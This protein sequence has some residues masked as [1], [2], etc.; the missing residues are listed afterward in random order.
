M[1]ITP[2]DTRSSEHPGDLLAWLRENAE[3]NDESL[4]RLRK[5]LSAAIQT[6]LTPRQQQILQLYLSSGLRGREIAAQ[7]GVA[8]STVSRTLSR[9]LGKLYK[10]LQWSF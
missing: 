8:P 7:L 4:L 6:E 9:A 3:T 10:V 2:F 5:N 1:T